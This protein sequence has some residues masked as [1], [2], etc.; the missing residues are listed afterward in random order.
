MTAAAQVCAGAGIDLEG[1]DGVE[2]VLLM[3]VTRHP[4][5]INRVTVQASFLRRTGG[6]QWAR[7][8]SPDDGQPWALEDQAARDGFLAETVEILNLPP[9]RQSE[10]DWY[11]SIRADPATGGETELTQATIY[12]EDRAESELAFRN[13]GLERHTVPR[14]LEVGVACDP[15]ERIVEICA[16]G[17]HKL[18][19]DYLK[20]FAPH[21][22][23]PVEVPRRDAQL[24]SLRASPDLR[25]LLS[26]RIERVEVSSLSLRSA[27]GTFLMVEKRGEHE[28]LYPFLERRFGP[29]SPLRAGGWQIVAATMRIFLIASDGK[30][31]RT[32]TVTLRSPNTTSVQTTLDCLCGMK[33]RLAR[34][35]NAPCQ[36]FGKPSAPW[37]GCQATRPERYVTKPSLHSCA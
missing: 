1:L 4:R 23:A 22:E 19:N 27:D 15:K 10:A 7:F 11:R 20:S 12:V 9:H 33:P 31:E 2:D 21:S 16:K 14:V 34:P 24:D 37:R 5:M 18:G 25:T 6:R 17:R 26:N 3:L 32:R 8:Q 13:S 30:K 28:T 29:A 35:P 36:A